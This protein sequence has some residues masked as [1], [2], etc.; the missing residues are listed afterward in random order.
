MIALLDGDILVHRVASIKKGGVQAVYYLLNKLIHDIREEA[1]CSQY[2]VFLTGSKNFRKDLHDGYKAQ[3][4][5]EKPKYF[6]EAREYLI[7]DKGAIVSV[8]C[9]ADD[10]LGVNQRD[11]TVICT[12]DKDLLQIPGRHYS[13]AIMH[14]EKVVRE[15]FHTTTDYLSGLRLFYKQMITGDAVDNIKC[16]PKY[17]PKKASALL[18]ELEVE[19]EMIDVVHSLYEQHN[20]IEM[21]DINT[22]LLWIWRHL[23][24]TYTV[25]RDIRADTATELPH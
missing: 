21:F 19:T 14:G 25:R 13:W 5:I 11:N 1:H 4:P 15:A 24:E 6:R 9:E 22:D 7:K 16:I 3:R 2:T 18:D 23:G 8:G 17:G 20:M 12:I 10:L